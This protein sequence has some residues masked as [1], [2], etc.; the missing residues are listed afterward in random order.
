VINSRNDAPM[1]PVKIPRMQKK[2]YDRMVRDQYIA[3]IAF[4]AAEFPYIAPFLYVFDGRYLY[5]LSTNYG[6][7]IDYFKAN[8]K[9]SV[10]IEEYKKDLSSFHFISLQGNL[11]EVTGGPEKKKIRERFV[12]LIRGKKLSGNILA[13]LGYDPADPPDAILKGDRTLVWKL[14]GVKDIVAL[15]NG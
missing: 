15:K 3:H 2:E 14:T 9:V 6:R 13:A 11:A 10:E 7:K 4:A 8:P 1:E 5:F 12:A